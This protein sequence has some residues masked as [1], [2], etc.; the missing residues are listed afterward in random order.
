MMMMILF[1]WCE[2]T[3]LFSSLS[4]FFFT[5]RSQ[6]CFFRSSGEE[7][8]E[9]LWP[10]VK[11][12]RALQWQMIDKMKREKGNLLRR[13]WSGEDGHCPVHHSAEQ[14]QLVLLMAPF[15]IHRQHSYN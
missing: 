1:D 7:T 9:S 11:T 12:I 13:E 14:Q 8:S 4:F 6:K 15:P 5:A 10:T 3:L 2:V